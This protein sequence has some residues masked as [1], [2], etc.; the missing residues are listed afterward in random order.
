MLVDAADYH[1]MKERPL[2][3]R[4][5]RPPLVAVIPVHGTI[6]HAGGPLGSFAT[7]ERVAKMLRVAR[8]DRRVRGVVLHVDSPGGSALASDRMHHEIVQLAREKPVVACMANVAASGG[9]YVSA[10]ARKI[11]AEPTTITGSIG[12][13]GA[14]VSLEPLFEKLG[15][16]TEIVRRG[17]HAGL[18]AAASRIDDDERGAI[19]R[20]LDATYRTFIGVVA[21]G[22]HMEEARVEEL[23]RGRVYTGKDAHA[24]GLVDVLGG[25]DVALRE[26]K[27]LLPEAVREKVVVVAARTPR[28][29]VPVLDLPAPASALLLAANGERVLTMQLETFDA[30]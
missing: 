21:R 29:D 12:V 23:A 22:R 18:L 13:V 26:V 6:A 2:L 8:M 9:Y 5:R 17:A 4:V 14:R 15:I 16:T 27:A 30:R 11:V 19:R 10:P 24:A 28:K 7:D 1:A 20:E 25:F 3:R